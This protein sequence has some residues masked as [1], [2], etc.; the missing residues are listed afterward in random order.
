MIPDW[1]E[2]MDGGAPILLI[3]PHGGRAAPDSHG[4]LAPRVN[5]LHTAELTR[6]LAGRLDAVALINAGMDRNLVDCNRLGQVAARAPWLLAMIAERLERMVAEQ[7]RA[8]VL[9]IHGW[10]LV[11][12]RVDIGVG[13]TER[14]GALAPPRD[15]HVSVSDRFLSGTLRTLIDRLGRAGIVSTFGMRY[16]AGGAQ[17]LVQACTGRHLRSEV[18]ALRRIAALGARGVIEAVQLELSIALRFP[19]ALRDDTVASMVEVLSR[20]GTAAGD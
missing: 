18:A 14:G 2:V 5:D 11:E 12:P 13:L 15:A 8:L 9:A 17:N 19:G 3:A 16:P 20:E 4:L 7:G 6:E 10:N 1:L